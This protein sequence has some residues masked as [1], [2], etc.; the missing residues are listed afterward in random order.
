MNSVLLDS[1]PK[2]GPKTAVLL[3]ARGL[4]TAADLLTYYP[5]R[6][7]D[8][9]KIVPISTANAGKTMVLKGVV[10]DIRTR[11]AWKKRMAITEALIEDPSGNITALW[12]NQPYL[13]KMLR[14]NPAEFFFAGPIERRGSKLQITNPIWEKVGE[15]PVHLG[16]IVPVYPSIG[17]LSARQFRFWFQ[18]ISS[19]F[20]KIKETLPPDTLFRQKLMPRQEALREI[21][22]PSSWE[23]LTAARRRM[24]FEEMFVLARAHLEKHIKRKTQKARIISGNLKPFLESLPFLLTSAQRRC[25]AEAL[26]DLGRPH[27]MRRLLNGDVGSGKTVLAAALALLTAQNRLQTALMAPTDILAHQHYDT[28]KLFLEPHD[29]SVAL[30]TASHPAGADTLA[31]ADVVVGTHAL[32]QKKVRLPRLA[33]AIVDEQHRFGAEQ[34]EALLHRGPPGKVPHYLS[35]TATPIPQTLAQI[36][37]GDMDISLLNELPKNRL[38]VKTYFVPPNKRADAYDFIARELDRHRQAF[39]ICPLIDPSDELG[40]TSVTEEYEKLKVIFKKYQVAPLHGALPARAKQDLLSRARS[41]KVDIIVST[42]VVEVGIDLPDAT[43]MMIEGA[44][45]FGLA[46]LHQFRGRVGR[47]NRQSYCLLFAGDASDA[48]RE[49]LR[50]IIRTADGFKLAEADLKQRG[51]GD[52]WGNVQSG[53]IDFQFADLWDLKL[54]KKVREELLQISK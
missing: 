3:A 10:K 41:K 52:L 51:P 19:E 20:Q 45:R 33:L 18:I 9:S 13:E 42:S 43:V 14:E 15:R 34:R 40:V 46:Q 2:I 25:L 11:R 32:I 54:I 8:F 53:W 28:L 23:S 26:V 38:P 24:A 44:D 29:A 17:P 4:R 27:P 30:H 22:F 1:L 31:A 35:L 36:L 12:F 21:H 5:R 50:T 49:R 47:S 48:A 16:K 6:Y 39:V 37:Y 7:E